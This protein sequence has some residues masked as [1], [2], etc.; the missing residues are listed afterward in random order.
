MNCN[1]L[2]IVFVTKAKKALKDK[3]S[4][5]LALLKVT[6]VLLMQLAIAKTAEAIEVRNLKSFYPLQIQ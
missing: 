6:V 1:T 4:P 3:R 2:Q 5:E